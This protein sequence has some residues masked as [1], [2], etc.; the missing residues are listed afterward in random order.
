MVNGDKNIDGSDR[1]PR[2]GMMTMV[3]ENR[4]EAWVVAALQNVNAPIGEAAVGVIHLTEAE[5]YRLLI[6]DA[7][8]DENRDEE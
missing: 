7:D 3:A 6:G 1:P 8:K 4:S 2:F 5:L